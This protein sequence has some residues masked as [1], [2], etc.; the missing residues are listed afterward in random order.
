MKVKKFVSRKS[1]SGHTYVKIEL[2]RLSMSTSVF[3]RLA[4]S[5]KGIKS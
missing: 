1:T 4:V 2:S 5:T 3:D